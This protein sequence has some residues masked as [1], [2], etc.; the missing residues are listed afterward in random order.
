MTSSE[1]DK[2]PKLLMS[3]AE[4][5]RRFGIEAPADAIGIVVLGQINTPVQEI[6]FTDEASDELAWLERLG[7]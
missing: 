3:R 2:V 5:R 6:V 1:P 7:K 4:Y